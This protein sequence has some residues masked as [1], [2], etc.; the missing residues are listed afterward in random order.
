[1]AT[2]APVIE[3][4]GGG[5]D[6][7]PRRRRVA[8]EPAQPL[9]ID[10]EL[11]RPVGGA[12]IER[13][14]GV[15]ADDSIG[16]DTVVALHPLDCLR[17]LRRVGLRRRRLQLAGVEIAVACK[18]L[19]DPRNARVG[20]ARLDR[21]AAFDLRGV[22]A[23]CLLRVADELAR[24]GTVLVGLGRKRSQPLADLAGRYG[25]D[26]S[27][28]YVGLRPRHG[29]DVANFAR[30]GEA[31]GQGGGIIEGRLGQRGLAPRR[32]AGK[33]AVDESGC[34]EP[35]AAGAF[36]RLH[37]LARL[38]LVP[39]GLPL[40]SLVEAARLVVVDRGA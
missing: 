27:R 16:V 11:P 8:V 31:V 38:G 13:P 5:V 33:L 22:T 3:E 26:Q 40:D 12:G 17:N 23:L 24:Q 19:D 29:V 1:M 20:V 4:G 37:Q 21:V 25:P 32:V 28:S 35:V 14:Q 6:V 34:V 15:L 18:R 39:D 7:D 9:E 10:R 2:V 36:E 30:I